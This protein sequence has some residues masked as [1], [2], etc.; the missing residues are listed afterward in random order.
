M[1]KYLFLPTLMALVLVFMAATNITFAPNKVESKA[2]FSELLAAF[3][4]GS[5]PYAININQV[6]TFLYQDESDNINVLSPAIPRNVAS[7][8]PGT[9]SEKFSRMPTVTTPFRAIETPDKYILVYHYGYMGFGVGKFLVAAFDKKGKLIKEDFLAELDGENPI[10]GQ[11][12]ADFKITRVT[13]K[14]TWDEEHTKIVSLE[15]QS[16]ASSQLLRAPKNVI[17][18]VPQESVKRA[19]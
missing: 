14:V 6:K 1:K 13:Y 10:A 9:E 19:K 12:D 5:L 11:I 4:K 16:V 8:L 2:K 3:P 7:L 17:P 15:K 18:A